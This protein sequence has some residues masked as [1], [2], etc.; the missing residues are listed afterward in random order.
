MTTPHKHAEFI[1]ASAAGA[2]VEYAFNLFDRWR[3]VTHFGMFDISDCRFRLTPPRWQ[4]E[5]DAQKAGSMLQCRTRDDG[6]WFDLV[7][8]AHGFKEPNSEFR[9]KPEVLRY[10]VA[11]ARSED[12]SFVAVISNTLDDAARMGRCV[13]FVEWLDDWQEVEVPA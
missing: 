13:D 6:R 12:G 10:R 8:S 2:G 5:I 9:I 3:R 1:N 7:V 4:R 11:R